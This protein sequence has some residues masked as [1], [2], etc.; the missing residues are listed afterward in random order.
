MLEFRKAGSF[1]PKLGE[2]PK[3]LICAILYR[4]RVYSTPWRKG[5][6]VGGGL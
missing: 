4:A 6:E 5:H 2:L 3:L 1:S